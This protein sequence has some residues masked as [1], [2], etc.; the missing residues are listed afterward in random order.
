VAATRKPQRK[1][2]EGQEFYS[3]QAAA[4]ALQRSPR[5]LRRLEAAGIIP[6]PRHELP[7]SRPGMRWYSTADLAE[8]QRLVE[9]SGYAERQPGSRGKL[10]SLLD[11]LAGAAR[12]D[13]RRSSWSGEEVSAK[14]RQFA[15]RHDPDTAFDWVPPSERRREEEQHL[16]PI[17]PADLCPRCKTVELVW[18]TQ[19]LPGGGVGPD[20]GVRT[21]RW[22]R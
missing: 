9:E 11:G 19:D 15:R 16:E 7:Y 6:R 1:V 5:T 8:L 12:T 22:R 21:L 4:E 20:P 10:K 2:F 17:P 13:T 3:V 18:V 14:P